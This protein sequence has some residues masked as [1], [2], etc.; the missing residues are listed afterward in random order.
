MISSAADYR[1]VDFA[2]GDLPTDRFDGNIMPLRSGDAQGM[3]KAEDIAFLVECVRDKADAFKNLAF[4]SDGYTPDRTTPEPVVPTKTLSGSQMRSIRSYLGECLRRGNGD[5]IEGVYFLKSPLEER[6]RIETSE[7]LYISLPGGGPTMQTIKSAHIGAWPETTSVTDFE[8]GAKVAKTPVLHL[9]SDAANLVAPAYFLYFG[10]EFFDTSTET[11]GKYY[12]SGSIVTQDYYRFGYFVDVWGVGSSRA[13]LRF[14][15]RVKDGVTPIVA[16]V[17][18]DYI[19]DARLWLV[20]SALNS[21]IPREGYGKF[22]AS[23]GMICLDRGSGSEVYVSREHQD[24]K[25]V[26][27]MNG[28]TSVYLMNRIIRDCGWVRYSEDEVNNQWILPLY[29]SWLIVE[30]TPNGRTKWW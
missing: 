19:A 9:F 22:Y 5:P 8:R 4:P 21:Y 18:D 14:T 28:F 30:A 15:S 27:K 16:Q 23:T 29:D 25:F 6:T 17:D 12:S 26:W 2:S 1:F 24:G 13:F 10:H 11:I 20:Y 3:L 7:H